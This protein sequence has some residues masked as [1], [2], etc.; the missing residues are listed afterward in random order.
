[1]VEGKLKNITLP[2]SIKKILKTVWEQFAY[3]GYVIAIGDLFTFLAFAY[4]LRV[5]IS[6][7]FMAVLFLIVF[8]CNYFNRWKEM[9]QDAITNP[10]RTKVMKKY[11]TLI[12]ILI[13]IYFITAL[14]LTIYYSS[15]Q[16]LLVAL[17]LTFSGLAYTLFL[18]GIS[19]KITGF[20]NFAIS[21]PY[22]AAVILFAY[23]YGLS[24]SLSVLLMMLFY[25][26]RVLMSTIFFD[27]K[28]IESDTSIG[29]KTFP[30]V[31]GEKRTIRALKFINPL[32][33]IPILL[34]VY[35]KVLPIFTLAIL[36]TIPYAFYYYRTSQDQRINKAILY[37]V[38]ADGEFAVWL[39]F[40][41][42]GK[43][44]MQGF[45]WL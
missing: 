33:G 44:V 20:K 14:G 24:L 23:Y 21:L 36:L 2:L 27:I 7:D 41:V 8:G 29:L 11:L 43:S 10:E 39:P 6:W 38:I 18:K 42:F 28:D 16:A 31:M 19:Q 5:K 15:F 13:P 40:I 4:I 22:S 37:N 9:K 3:G 30:S 34:G 12:P 17:F 25:F 32:S 35:L 1:M 26:L 45:H